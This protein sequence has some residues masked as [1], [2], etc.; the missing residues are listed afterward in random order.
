MPYFRSVVT[1]WTILIPLFGIQPEPLT[2][3]VGQSTLSRD[4][5]TTVRLLAVDKEGRSEDVTDKAL[6]LVTPSDAVRIEGHTLTAL[7]DGNVTLQAEYEGLYSNPLTLTIY[8]EVDGHRLPPEPDP[9]VNNATLLGVDVNRNGV[10]DD[11]ERWIYKEYKNL[12]E[13]GIMLQ[14]A[15]G[16]QKKIS[17]IGKAHEYIKLTNKSLSCEYY[18]EEKYDWFRRKYEYTTTIHELKKIQ[19]NTIKRHIA[20]E[21]YNAEFNGKTFDEKILPDKNNCDF[22]KN[23]NIKNLP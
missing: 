10:R 13:R 21:R 7:K 8:W 19:F 4:H 14:N 20:Y 2:L 9:K 11:V 5:N 12:I 22:D 6:W 18:L 1:L 3:V 15:Y 16:L 17:N 23:G